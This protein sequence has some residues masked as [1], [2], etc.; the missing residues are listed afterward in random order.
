MP[1]TGCPST[2]NPV[3]RLSRNRIRA[4]LVGGG[5]TWH[6]APTS[7]SMGLGRY[8]RLKSDYERLPATTEATIRIAMIRLMVRRLAV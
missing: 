4:R 8:R 6:I 2:S 5:P 3:G 7:D 1:L